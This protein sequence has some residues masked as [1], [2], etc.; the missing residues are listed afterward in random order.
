MAVES[1]ALSPTASA[2]SKDMK[3]AEI[4]GSFV[5][6]EVDNASPE[7]GDYSGAAKKTDP[8]EIALVKKLD[9]M[10]M[11]RH[12]PYSLSPQTCE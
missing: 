11:V 8:A 2:V 6:K 7:G 12:S 4:E 9:R 5:G 1:K 3:A 10:I